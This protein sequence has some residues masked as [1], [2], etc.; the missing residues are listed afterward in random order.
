[1]GLAEVKRKQRLVGS[2]RTSN[3][4]W[5]NDASL[6]G[7]RLLA[8]MGWNAGE[9]LGANNTGT[10][11][12]ITMALKL[13]NTGIGVDRAHREAKAKN[14][15]G[16]WVGANGELDALYAQLSAAASASSSSGAQTPPV[17]TSEAT[18]VMDSPKPV[19]NRGRRVRRRDRTA[20]N[21][22]DSPGPEVQSPLP[23]HRNDSSTNENSKEG[24]QKKMM[25]HKLDGE[26]LKKEKREKKKKKRERH[27]DCTPSDGEEESR[28]RKQDKRKKRRE[29]EAAR[30][31]QQ[32]SSDEIIKKDPE[33][34]RTQTEG[35]ENI[36]SQYGVFQYLSNRLVVRR[37]QVRREKGIF[38]KNAHIV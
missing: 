20:E 15:N 7:Q 12:P 30:V 23:Q 9:G 11:A 32:G 10:N 36:I 8:S 14:P 16:V 1:M 18:S 17:S 21:F 22:V 26:A 34:A 13:D 3:A 4:T 28:E 5:S 25:K 24:D 29:K 31:A 27:D 2:A 19:L 33:P 37:A 6:P 38:A 35:P